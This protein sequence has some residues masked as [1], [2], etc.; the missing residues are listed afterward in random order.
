MH[1]IG[2]CVGDGV[3]AGVGASVGDGVVLVSQSSKPCGH[4]E[5]DTLKKG[6]Q[7]LSVFLQTPKVF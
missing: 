4:S 7:R 2:E 3:G 6:K 5:A 1:T